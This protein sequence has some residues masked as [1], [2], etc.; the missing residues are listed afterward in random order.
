M[1]VRVW[2]ARAAPENVPSYRQ[3]LETHVF[4]ILQSLS[5]FI[6]AD[7]MERVDDEE[8]ELVVTSR[9]Q[10][11]KAVREF[12]GDAYERAVVAPGARAVLASYESDVEH[13]E[14]TAECKA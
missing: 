10:S 2:R 9:W 11:L 1:I 5:G 13:Y 12:A 4:P 14:V 8:V 3:H 6:G 7:L